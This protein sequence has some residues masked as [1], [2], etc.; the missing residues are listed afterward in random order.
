MGQNATGNARCHSQTW[1]LPLPSDPM[2]NSL[3]AFKIAPYFLN[4]ALYGVSH[5]LL[6]FF[7]HCK[8]HDRLRSL[9]NCIIHEKSKAGKE[10][11]YST[12][13]NYYYYY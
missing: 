11:I 3:A 12:K 13:S 5:I 9:Y 4:S 7:N 1:P 10:C 8:Q 2:S 6:L